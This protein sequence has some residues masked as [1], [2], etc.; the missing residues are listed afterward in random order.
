MLYLI[1]FEIVTL[2]SH[3]FSKSK[4]FI[5]SEAIDSTIKIHFQANENVCWLQ[6]EVI[7]RVKPSH[8]ILCD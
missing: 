6:E 5:F 2:L 1:Y 8:I 4:T 7:K 3:Y